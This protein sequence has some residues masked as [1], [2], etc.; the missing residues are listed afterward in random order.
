MP[1]VQAVAA[2]PAAAAAAEPPT[3]QM[4][5]MGIRQDAGRPRQGAGE[6]RP[7]RRRRDEEERVDTRPPNRDVKTGQAGMA[8][9]IVANYFALK[10]RPEWRI[11]QYNVDFNPDIQSI[12]M[13]R[14][15]LS[16]FQERI[17]PTNAFD[18][19]I[20]YLTK[21]LDD[22]PTELTATRDTDNSIVN[23]TITRTADL[24]PTSPQ[25]LPMFNV[26]FRRVLLKLGM[27]QIQRHYFSPA[28]QERTKLPAHK[29]EIWPG[30]ATAIGQY[31]GRVMLCA[32]VA[33]KVLRTETVL[34]VISDITRSRPPN[35]RD[36]VYKK[37][38][39][40]IVMTRY[41]N[42]TYR[43]E[44]INWDV[45]PRHS[46]KKSKGEEISYIDYYQKVIPGKH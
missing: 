25:L 10:T 5:A 6:Q 28:E 9:D 16:K 35:V 7:G 15:M 39:G 38:V 11:Y 8:V 40:S 21:K 32:D 1:Q 18:G 19:R 31:E 22:D 34:D 37:L 12:R 17:G 14:S 46:F 29:L 43:V 36:A 33:H 23:I 42:K 27:Q 30:Y 44:D 20:L 24:P 3:Q 2:T 45:T 26:V 13:K 4:A 41:N